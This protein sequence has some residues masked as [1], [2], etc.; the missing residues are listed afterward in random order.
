MRIKDR[1]FSWYMNFLLLSN[2]NLNLK[3]TVGYNNKFL[4]NNVEKN[5][6]KV[7]VYQKRLPVTTSESSREQVVPRAACKR[8]F[9]KS[10]D[11]LMKEN[12]QLTESRK[13][14]VKKYNESNH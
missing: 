3:K 2:L 10:T 6:N 5:I 8:H 1:F 7:L 4:I 13:M 12:I 9:V 14:L 11:N